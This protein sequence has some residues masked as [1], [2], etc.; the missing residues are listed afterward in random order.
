MA[1]ET[2]DSAW[3]WEAATITK[4]SKKREME[5]FQE[6]SPGGELESGTYCAHPT[7]STIGL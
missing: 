7:A 5:T 4:N 2:K 1:R 3:V 6:L